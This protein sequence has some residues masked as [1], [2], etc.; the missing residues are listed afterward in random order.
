M[1][2]ATDRKLECQP[3]GYFFADALS[4]YELPRQ[5]ANQK[6]AGQIV[7]NPHNNFEQALEDLAGFD[8]IWILFWFHAKQSWQ[9]KVKPPRGGKKRG[10]FATRSPHRPNP[11]GLTSVL[12][13][14]IEGRVLFIEEHDL[15]NE[16]PILDIKP[17]LA[18]ADAHPE[19]KEGWL[20]E[21]PPPA[22]EI[23]ISDLASK[24]S[25]WIEAKSGLNLVQAVLPLLQQNPYPSRFNR[26]KKFKKLGDESY[27]LA[28]KTWRVR[29]QIDQAANSLLVED[30]LSGYTIE[31]LE[32][33][34]KY[35]DHE[36]HRE[37][38]REPPC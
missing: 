3:I 11:I 13:K 29:F 21:N 36:L 12:L 16:T 24:K 27:L 31:S 15:L 25:S 2:K 10:L 26:I 23:N 33:S 30:I 19:A 22:F 20:V 6:N 17:Y 7:L 28:F 9:P 32:T 38:L 8:R 34:K 18:Y 4:T 1:Q 37:F 5:G 14:K 35:A